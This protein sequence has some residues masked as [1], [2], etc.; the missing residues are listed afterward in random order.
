M[1]PITER[2][3]RASFVNCSKGDAKRLQVAHQVRPADLALLIAAAMPDPAEQ[4]AAA[5]APAPAEPVRWPWSVEAFRHRLAEARR[6]LGLPST[7]PET[8]PP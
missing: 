5:T 6:C 2:D 4:L 3:I 8:A 1:D 7:D